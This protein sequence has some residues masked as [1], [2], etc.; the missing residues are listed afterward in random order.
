M[1]NGLLKFLL[2]ALLVSS[3]QAEAPKVVRAC[4]V[5]WHPFVSTVDGKVSGNDTEVLQKAVKEIGCD[6][7][8][9]QDVPWKRCLKM[10]EDGEV[11]VIYPASKSPDREFFLHYPQTA[12]HH[13][14]YVFIT[15]VDAQQE[16]S[17]KRDVSS[18]PQPIG[19]PLGYSVSEQLH[20]EKGA[21]F[22]ENAKDDR[23]NLEKLSLGRVGTII[24]ER[25]SG[26]DLMHKLKADKT[27]VMLDPPYLQDKEYYIA[28]SKKSAIAIDLRNALDKVLPKLVQEKG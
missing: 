15:K 8:E 7:V 23:T 6:R 5:A 28:V 27:L 19:I 25:M 13:V 17:T 21:R 2:S 18:L 22:D 4:T 12:L 24:I 9:V 14:S 26:L 10:A 3:S 20:K 11:D 1:R 16:W